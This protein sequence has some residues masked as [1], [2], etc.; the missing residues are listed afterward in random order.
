[1]YHR[2]SDVERDPWRLAVSPRHFAEH[3]EVLRTSY[4]LVNASE[5]GA[6]MAAGTMRAGTVALTFDDGAV[7]NADVAAPL[8][9]QAGVP[10]TFFIPTGLLGSE[11]EF[12]W[13][14]LEHIILAP[15][16]LP[17][18]LRSS[19]LNTFWPV[20]PTRY[21]PSAAA[22][23]RTWRAETQGRTGRQRLYNEIWRALMALPHEKRA[24]ALDELRAAAGADRPARAAHRP[25]DAMELA[26]LAARAGLEVG[27][28]AVTHTVLSSLPQEQQEWELRTSKARLEEILGRPVTS[29]S[30][31]NGG[32]DAVTPS[33]ARQAGYTVGFTAS[34]GLVTRHTPVMLIPRVIPPDVGGDRFAR[35]LDGLVAPVSS[36]ARRTTLA[37]PAS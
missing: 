28:H 22:R 26:S 3:L 14:D 4:L 34:F 20:E 10:A 35:W 33:I 11:R 15:G 9:E 8:L 21:D 5:L 13:D 6:S 31:P 25:M 17:P 18:V 32:H 37:A 2:V 36:S 27:S 12:W 7:D 1:M 24:V 19:S 30:Y 16:E 29:L 23:D